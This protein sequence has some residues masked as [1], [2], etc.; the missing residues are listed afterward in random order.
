MRGSFVFLVACRGV[1]STARY[2]AFPDADH[3]S[4]ASSGCR[5]FG[6]HDRIHLCFGSRC[7]VL[8]VT[9]LVGILA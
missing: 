7:D 1:G 9:I 5:Q 6:R 8:V 2:F 4:G 3:P